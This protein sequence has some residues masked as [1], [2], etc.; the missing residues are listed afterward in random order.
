MLT[1]KPLQWTVG[2]STSTEKPPSEFVPATVPGAVQLDWARAKKWG[3]HFFAENWKEYRWMEDV[4]WTYQTKLELPPLAAGESVSFVC[5]GVDYRFIVRLNGA[6]VHDQEGMFTPFE[7]DLRRAKSGDLLEVVVFPAPKSCEK[8]VDRNQANQSVKPAVSYEWDFHPRLIPLG[9][10][11]ETY[12]E[13]RPAQHLWT[14][15]TFYELTPDCSSAAL[16][17]RADVDGKGDAQLHWQLLDPSG[18]VVAEQR[19]PA[20]SKI[21]ATLSKPELWWPNGQ[22]AQTLYTSRVSLVNST[23]KAIDVRESRVG[24]RRVRLVMAPGSWDWP[25]GHEF[26][27]GPSNPPITM[28]VNGRAIFCKGSNWVGP[29][30]FPGTVTAETYRPLLDLVK[31]ANMNMLRLWGG[32]AINKTAFYE[33]CDERGIMIW[34]EFPLACNRYEGTPAYLSVLDQESQSII[35]KLRGHA[36][37]VMWCGGNELF[38]NWSL[39][40]NQDLALRLLNRNCYDLDPQRPF[41]MTSPI[42]GMGHGHYLFRDPMGNEVF[43]LFS[44]AKCSAY[45]EFGCPGPASVATLKKIIPEAELFPPRL[46]TSWVSHHA[47]GAWGADAGSW[48]MLHQ[49]EDYFG[50]C[51]SIEDVVNGGQL[52]Q[53]EGYKCIFEEARRQKPTASMALNWCFNEPW[54]TAAN[55]S[56]I[57]WPAEPKRGYAQVA[58]ACRPVLASARIPKFRWKEGESFTP[59]LWLL[60]DSPQRVAAGRVDVSLVNGAEKIPLL[61]WDFPALEPNVNLAGPVIRF[62]LPPLPSTIMKLVLSVPGRAEL[63]SEYTLVFVPLKQRVEAAGARALNL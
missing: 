3:P 42:M 4:Y 52:L 62:A 34:Q 49:I 59:E 17:I 30:I 24:F 44:R 22:G 8:P 60:N 14:A 2:F 47:F 15:E 21:T 57:S 58:K 1:R 56:L 10:W 7:V 36:C 5:K 35:C 19:G 13:V 25:I 37:L 11:D 26:P 38:N 6:T 16:S 55:N 12:L 48:L 32:A 54:P 43:Q 20:E 63:D 18:K 50:A 41:L 53:G 46:G 39:M 23:G 27:K 51:K 61:S 45:T 9:I 29:D 31:A 28:E 33:M 40:T